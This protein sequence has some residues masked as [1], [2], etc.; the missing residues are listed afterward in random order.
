MDI[1]LAGNDVYTY[2]FTDFKITEVILQCLLFNSSFD[3]LANTT[4]RIHPLLKPSTGGNIHDHEKVITNSHGLRLIYDDLLHGRFGNLSHED[5]YGVAISIVTK[6]PIGQNNYMSMLLDLEKD[7]VLSFF[8]STKHHELNVLTKGRF[9]YIPFIGIPL[10][11][12]HA[13][14]FCF[15]DNNSRIAAAVSYFGQPMD[16]A[17]ASNLISGQHKVLNDGVFRRSTQDAIV[18]LRTEK[19]LADLLENYVLDTSYFYQHTS[20]IKVEALESF[21]E[22]LPDRYTQNE[23]VNEVFERNTDYFI[24]EYGS[25]AAA[26]LHKA[27]AKEQ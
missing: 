26:A 9:N 8:I 1:Q 27:L 7:K 22:L 2:N 20:K 4:V 19:V 17:V 6:L 25:I 3:H 5:Y 10:Q 24:K 11:I 18:S 14:D 13:M 15:V 16:W 21:R 23:K 12:K